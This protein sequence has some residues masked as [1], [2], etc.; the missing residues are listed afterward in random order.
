M[1]KIFAAIALVLGMIVSTSGTASADTWWHPS[2]AHAMPLH[3]VL[4]TP[5]NVLDV[6][7]PCTVGLRGLGCNGTLPQPAV[8]DVDGDY[9][10][11]SGNGVHASHGVGEAFQARGQFT[12]CY[13]DAG[14]QEGQNPGSGPYD[15][16]PAY[17]FPTD[18]QAGASDWG[19]WWIDFTAPGTGTTSPDPRVLAVIEKRIQ[20]WCL[21]LIPVEPDLS[22]CGATR[23]GG[24]EFDEVDYW[25]NKGNGYPD[26]TPAS[27]LV[28]NRALYDLAHKYGLAAIHKGDMAQV[29][30]LQPYADATLN[31]ECSQYRECDDLASFSS[32]GKA[33]W[34]AEY[35]ANPFSRL[36]DS[37]G[38]V[39]RHW[40]GARYK[41]GLPNHGGR[42]PC[43]GTW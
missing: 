39:A 34:V 8:M 24:I 32:N 40:N 22:R 43:P 29:A 3:W 5:S 21:N 12:I 19:G 38:A 20:D 25:E 18:R 27:Q 7:D 16:E 9:N 17:R 33:V 41:L 6:N 11:R 23:C 36:C 2:S 30:Q 14:V 15:R 13:M 42:Q 26:V 10:T 35:K 31:E 4:D 37:Y 28:Y 1:R